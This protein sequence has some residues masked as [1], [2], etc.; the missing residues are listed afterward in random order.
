MRERIAKAICDFQ[1]NG[2]GVHDE[3]L[4]PEGGDALDGICNDIADVVLTAMLEPT[5]AMLVEGS[6]EVPAF[7]GT[8]AAREHVRTN[9]WQAMIKAA[10]H[11]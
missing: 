9:V 11:E 6:M 1:T 4:C 10:Q 2:T 3:W 8:V 5:D 7:K